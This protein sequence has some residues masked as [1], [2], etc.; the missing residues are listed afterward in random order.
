LHRYA[1]YP[2]GSGN[3]YAL[4]IN[5]DCMGLVY[6]KDLLSDPQEKEA[7]RKKHGRELDVPETYDEM[8]EVAAFF[9]RPEENLYGIGL[10]G[11][12]SYDACTSAFNCLLWSYGGDLWDAATR[13]VKGVLNAPVSVRALQGF[14]QLFSYAPPGATDWYATELN[15]AIESGQVAMAINWYYFFSAHLDPAR[16]V[17]ASK[18]GFAALPGAKGPDG[19]LRRHVSVG[20]QGISISAYSRHK[21]QAWKFLEW[22]MSEEQQW[23]W[24][25]G[26]GKTGR[27]S[28]LTDPKF[29]KATPYNET[30]AFS[31]GMTKDYWH[32]PEYVELLELY[33]KHI[34]AAVSGKVSAQDALDKTA[35]EHE[36]ILRRA[37]Y[38]NEK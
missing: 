20:G 1:E 36:E 6:R 37:G 18:L 34:H 22:F 32:V 24:V 35:E 13:R 16:S 19:V 27:R 31:M 2:E 29:L 25:N 33:Q 38:V 14:T 10:Y 23:K 30:F 3:L 17:V 28:I 5:Q 11:S 26:G 15:R 8:L 9:T 12:D 4:P 7:F 21:E